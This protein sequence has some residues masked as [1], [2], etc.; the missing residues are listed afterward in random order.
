MTGMAEYVGRGLQILGVLGAFGSGSFALFLL[1]WFQPHDINSVRMY[2]AYVYITLF[3]VLIPAAELNLMQHRH[4]VRF[5]RFMLS[6]VGR[7]FMYVFMGGLLLGQQVGGWV[8]GV[9]MIALG[10]LNLFAAPFTKNSAE[11]ST[12]GGMA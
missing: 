2:I 1:M 3:A 6:H 7:A 9:Y 8:V 12:T 4:L 5:S 11:V 10:V